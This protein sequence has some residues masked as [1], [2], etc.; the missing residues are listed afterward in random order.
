MDPSWKCCP[1]CLAPL[2]GWL[3]EIREDGPHS[4][5]TVHEGKSYL[6][7]GVDSEIRILGA[8]LS[9]VHAYLV[10]SDGICTIVDL[11]NGDSIE[12]NNAQTVKTTLID[13]DIVKLGDAHF[14]IKLI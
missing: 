11:G 5:Y 9:R 3:V 13:G 6:G 2:A 4:V 8:G 7:S 1:V 14:K 10:I 12:V